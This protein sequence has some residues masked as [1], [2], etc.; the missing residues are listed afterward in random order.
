MAQKKK[1]IIRA[2][3]KGWFPRTLFGRSLM[4]LVIPILLI[5]LTTTYIFFERHWTRMTDRLAFGVAAEIAWIADVLEKSPDSEDVK[6]IS[7][8]AAQHM[9]LLISF[10]PFAEGEEDAKLPT[11]RTERFFLAQTLSEVLEHKVRRPHS[12]EVDFEEKWVEITL[13]LNT[14]LLHVS[15]P[16][17][18]L[19]SSSGYIFLLWM[20]CVSVILLGIAIVFMRNQIR[21]IRRLAIVAER[22]GKGRGIPAS[23]KPEGAREVRQAA[24]SFLDMHERIRRQIQQRTAML[25]GVSHDLRTPL[26]RMKL[27]LAMMETSTDVEALKNDLADMERMLG[28]YLDFARGEGGEQASM[29]DMQEMLERVSHKM[30]RQGMSVELSID[31]ELNAH[32]RPVA[33]ERGF[34]NIL[35]NASKFAKGIWMTAHQDED[36]LYI[37]IEDDGPG[38]PEDQFDEVFKPFFTGEKSRNLETSGVGLGLSITQ[39]IILSHGGTIELS[40]STHGGLCVDIAIPL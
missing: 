7:G 13:K 2:A 21:P 27:Q 37:R 24:Q 20:T 19:F 33:M 31:G 25:S 10:E 18:R 6:R 5:Q 15:V 12:I 36:M 40:K 22:F 17:R 9:D 23:F 35:N 3:I 28:A 30:R 16:Q 1:K 14:G 8:Q 32:I 11:S 4:I 26:T 29:T 38:I 34:M 39:D